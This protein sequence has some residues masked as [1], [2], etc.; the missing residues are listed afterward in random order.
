MEEHEKKVVMALNECEKNGGTYLNLA[1][2]D[3][4]ILTS[5]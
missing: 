4:Y 5:L 1:G 2:K 3:N